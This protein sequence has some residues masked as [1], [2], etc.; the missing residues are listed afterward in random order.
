MLGIMKTT[1][2]V[3]NKTD[4]VIEGWYWVLRSDDLKPKKAKAITLMGRN[5]TVYRTD[6]GKPVILD[7]YCAHM[8]AHLAQGTVQG[9]SIRCMF[10]NWKYN[11]QGR[12]EEIPSLGG[13]CSLDVRVEAWP[14]EER[15]G[16]IW[17]WTGKKPEYPVPCPQELAGLKVQSVLAHA[18][19][20]KCHPHVVLINAIDEHH[21]NSVHQLPVLLQLEP[22][23]IHSKCIQ[24]SNT[25]RPQS[26]S[27]WGRILRKFYKNALTYSMTYWNGS[28]GT[29]TLGPDFLHFYILFALRPT[30]DGQT[31]GQTVLL[32]RQ[33]NGLGG[34][35]IN[36]VLLALTLLV[37]NF[38]A[39]GDTVIFSNIRF[40]IKTPI[41]ADHVILK[42]IQHLEQQTISN[43][44]ECDEA[45]KDAKKERICE[46][47][48]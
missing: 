45:S 25:T 12:C 41:K 7:A 11:N 1:Y 5:L 15:Y 47:V 18:F 30:H 29:V 23:N 37:G 28:T 27:L 13:S 46:A 44:S 38:F 32:T 33:R 21:F 2:N 42:F 9:D 4:K 6:K 8:G 22:L 24:F 43:W 39:K 10:H 26:C 20:Q 48:E 17:V 34:Y 31:E 14:C 19:N 16:L 40:E 3:F 36:H 35:F